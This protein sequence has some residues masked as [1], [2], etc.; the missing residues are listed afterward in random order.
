MNIKKII[1]GIQEDV[2]SLDKMK[3]E[4]IVWINKSIPIDIGVFKVEIKVEINIKILIIINLISINS[5]IK[6]LVLGT[7]DVA[8]TLLC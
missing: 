1:I 5:L 2:K 4:I 8:S 7:K 6:I 3:V